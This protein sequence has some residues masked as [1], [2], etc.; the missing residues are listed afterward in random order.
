MPRGQGFPEM[1]AGTL[2]K[3]HSQGCLGFLGVP[4]LQAPLAHPAGGKVKVRRVPILAATPRQDWL[5]LP[6]P[7]RL[8]FSLSL[9]FSPTAPG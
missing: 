3:G 7:G 1:G 6:T 9:T 4:G 5:C 8:L 2:D